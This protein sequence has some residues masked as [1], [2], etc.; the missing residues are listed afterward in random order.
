MDPREIAK[1]PQTDT[2]SGGV[3]LR[4]YITHGAHPYPESAFLGTIF[5]T[6]ATGFLCA[7]GDLFDLYRLLPDLTT[8]SN[9]LNIEYRI[10]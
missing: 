2:A 4:I 1:S 9:V 5:E 10:H 8:N 3:F 7:L 6:G